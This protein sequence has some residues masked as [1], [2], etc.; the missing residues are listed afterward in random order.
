MLTS[1][2]F[3]DPKQKKPIRTTEYGALFISDTLKTMFFTQPT[4]AEKNKTTPCNRYLISVISSVRQP[5]NQ[6][7]KIPNINNN[8][9]YKATYCM[10]KLKEDFA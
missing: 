5:M 9:K 2:I 10:L 8:N 1:S 6:D 4:Q 3:L 7:N